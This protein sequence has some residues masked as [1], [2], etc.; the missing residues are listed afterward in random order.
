[1]AA[2]RLAALCCQNWLGRPLQARPDL[3][4]ARRLAEGFDD[5]GMRVNVTQQQ[6][7]NAPL[8]GDTPMPSRRQCLGII[9]NHPARSQ[10][11]TFDRTR[12]VNGRSCRVWP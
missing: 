5:H 1:V 6:L 7:R 2:E 12:P 9:R 11:M 4:L 8:L 10:T 3:E